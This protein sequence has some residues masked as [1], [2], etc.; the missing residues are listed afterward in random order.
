[1]LFCHQWLQ[2]RV[3]CEDTRT[4]GDLVSSPGL[5]SAHNKRDSAQ[6]K[7]IPSPSR[8]AAFRG[9][10]SCVPKFLNKR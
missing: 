5:D 4:R 3:K 9:N 8:V 6:N 1:M 2:R 7:N 10:S